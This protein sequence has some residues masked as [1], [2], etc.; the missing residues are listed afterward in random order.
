LI[1]HCLDI[2]QS[3]RQ[4]SGRI[5]LTQIPVVFPIAHALAHGLLE[6]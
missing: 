1:R 5:G 4:N 2:R 3:Q 6:S